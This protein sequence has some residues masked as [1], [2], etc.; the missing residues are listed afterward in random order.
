[1]RRNA[2]PRLH[3][4]TL[5]EAGIVTVEEHSYGFPRVYAWNNET[6]LR[7]GKYCSIAEGVV[8]LLGGEHRMDWVTTF[9]FSAL[10]QEWPVASVIP[11]HPGT[12]GDVIIGNDVWIGHGAIL[13]SGIRIGDGVVVGAGS[14]VSRDVEDY[15]VVAGNPAKFV[16]FR[17]D[18]QTRNQ[19]KESSWWDWP[20][21]K[22]VANLAKLMNPPDGSIL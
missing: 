10:P 13:L 15:A 4:R 17:F 2:A 3:W 9:P 7:I 21:E 18:E 19:L 5:Q 12:K 14:V 1:M 8:I 16:K 22:V 11:G 6:K 20:H